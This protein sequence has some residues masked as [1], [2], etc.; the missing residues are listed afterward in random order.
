MQHFSDHPDSNLV[1]DKRLFPGLIEIIT[2]ALMLEMVDEADSVMQALHVLRP[3]A[4]TTDIFSA[5]I[6]IKRGRFIEAARS[7]K[8]VTDTPEMQS[9]ATALLAVCHY[10]IDDPEWKANV[11]EVLTKNDNPEAVLLVN[12]ML[13]RDVDVETVNTAKKA[14]APTA[15]AKDEV[16]WSKHYMKV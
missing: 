9:M 2:Q 16:D 1:C 14:D 3:S 12:A 6:L 11:T 10:S 13:G 4:N 8:N 15:A 7:L 5:W